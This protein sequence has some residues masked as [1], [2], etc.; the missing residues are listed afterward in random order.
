MRKNSSVTPTLSRGEQ[1]SRWWTAGE[2]QK[3]AAVSDQNT[4]V[5]ERSHPRRGSG[6]SWGLRLTLVYRASLDV[7]RD[8]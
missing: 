2:D 8:D 3:R 1:L 6:A 4:E 5:L 7:G